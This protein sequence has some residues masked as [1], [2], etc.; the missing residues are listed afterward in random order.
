MKRYIFVIMSFFICMQN[1]SVVY[2]DTLSQILNLY[3]TS[4][5]VI[6]IDNFMLELES[7]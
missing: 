7:S 1:F 3:G 6:D 2:A 5:E 4:T